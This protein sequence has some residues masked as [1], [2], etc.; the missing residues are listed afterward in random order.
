MFRGCRHQFLTLGVIFYP[1]AVHQFIRGPLRI[2][3]NPRSARD[4]EDA[5][6]PVGQSPLTRLRHS[7][8]QVHQGLLGE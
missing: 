5:A 2:F 7:S 6:R 1:T 3:G 8:R 4:Q